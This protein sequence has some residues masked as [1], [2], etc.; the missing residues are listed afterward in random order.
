MHRLLL[1]MLA[2]FYMPFAHSHGEV[3]P[4]TKW[5]ERLITF[6]D[7]AEYQ[8][9]VVD[10]HTHSAFSDGHVW[11]QIRVSEADRDGLDAM[12]VTEHLEWQPHLADIPH[13]DRNRAYEVTKE[14]AAQLDL[15]IIPGVEITR[16]SPA[17]HTNAIFIS[18]ANQL[19]K[20]SFPDDPSDPIAYYQQAGAW[21]PQE[22]IEAAN[23]QGAFVFWN[24][25]FYDRQK[26]DGIAVIPK[27]HQKN[28]K[29]NLL[30]GIEI[31]NGLAYSEE[32]FAIAL[33]YD[34]A[35]IGVS[36]IHDLIDW[37]YPP[38]EG[39]H[40]P[41]T[42][43]FAEER[44]LAGIKEALFAQRTVVWFRN[45]LLGREAWLLPLLEASITI[46]PIGYGEDNL[47]L[48]LKL[49]NDSDTRFLLHNESDYT[50]M[51][52]P[53]LLELPPHSDKTIHVKT[54]VKIDQIQLAFQVKNAL[55]APGKPASLTFDIP[56][57]SQQSG[58]P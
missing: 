29:K 20:A 43:V 9:L 26:P 56:I 18:D 21:D 48:G 12:A 32:A 36:D 8:T 17:G 50:F 27:F 31:A 28:A 25:P 33:K 24:H 37:D 40:R 57:P 44:S 55:T 39:H 5:E 11:P 42:L 58:A 41:V 46:T 2:G 16:D 14:A 52:Y 54:G 1:L 35:L 53:D 22:A 23:R 7:T 38:H 47:V 30:H 4:A 15:L 51:Q 19:F 13:P 34:L 45:L 6:P 49:R 3:E 10:L